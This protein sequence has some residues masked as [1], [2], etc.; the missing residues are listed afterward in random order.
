M[1]RL[2]ICGKYIKPN[3]SKPHMAQTLH[4]ANLF[5]NPKV[6]FTSLI[7]IFFKHMIVKISKRQHKYILK[8]QTYILNLHIHN[9][10]YLTYGSLKS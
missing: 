6:R 9:K 7:L 10:T 2:S 8:K 1:V 4:V 5:T 3:R